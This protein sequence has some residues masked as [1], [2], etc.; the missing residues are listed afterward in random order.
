[1]SHAVVYQSLTEEGK[2]IIR[3]FIE[4]GKQYDRKELVAVIRERASKKEEMS[5]GVV[6]GVIKSMTSSNEI[7]VVSRGKYRKGIPMNC[8]TM[9][10]KVLALLGKFKTELDKVCMVNAL[11]L[12]S[13]DIEFIGRLNEISDR[14]ESDI[15]T[16]EEVGEA[17]EPSADKVKEQKTAV[18]KAPDKAKANEKQAEKK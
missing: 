15:W 10:E 6:A 9:Q 11:T 13:G 12:K 2:E 8:Q 17:K 4:A 5:D 14:L 1:M 18:P 3:N 7:M 16:L